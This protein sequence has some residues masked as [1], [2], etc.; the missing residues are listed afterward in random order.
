M[1]LQDE[2][3]QADRKRQQHFLSTF[4]LTEVQEV[5]LKES[6]KEQKALRHMGLSANPIEKQ[7]HHGLWQTQLN[8]HYRGEVFHVDD[9]RQVC[10]EYHMRM[11][12]SHLY[13]GPVDPEFA[14][15]VKNFQRTH[16]LSDEEVSKEFFIVAP[17]KAFELE[18][19][20]RPVVDLD[21]VLLYRIDDNFFKLVHQWGCDLTLS[22]YVAS[23]KKRDLWNMTCHW[24]LMSFM[25]TMILLGFFVDSFGNACTLSLLISGLIAWMYYSSFRD[26][27]D[28]L[29]HRFSHYNWNQRW[30]Y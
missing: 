27:P 23:W 15:K 12:P 8:Q 21:P 9:V 30:T 13:R 19:R 22:R 17:A 4:S 6:K 2:L 14:V 7:K 24:F 1:N 10:M 3:I 16:H 29:R 28:E 20:Q 25:V 11:L 5:L 18:E 26:S